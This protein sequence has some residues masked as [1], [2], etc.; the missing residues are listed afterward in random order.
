[1]SPNSINKICSHKR[2]PLQ[3]IFINLSTY[4]AIEDVLLKITMILIEWMKYLCYN[5]A[6]TLMRP[7]LQFEMFEMFEI[8]NL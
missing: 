6:K 5:F 1:M 2:N 4:I 3:T 8:F 7:F